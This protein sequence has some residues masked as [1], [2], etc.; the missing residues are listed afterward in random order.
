MT[1]CWMGF[2][3]EKGQREKGARWVGGRGRGMGRG[4]LV[5]VPVPSLTIWFCN[6]VAYYGVD[7]KS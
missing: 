1:R 3:L 6:V 7:D 4:G 2:E 5:A